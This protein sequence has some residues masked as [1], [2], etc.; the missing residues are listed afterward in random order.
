MVSRIKEDPITFEQKIEILTIVGGG[1]GL[2]VSDTDARGIFF[3]F[4]LLF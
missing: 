4:A 2:K 1:Y 3:F